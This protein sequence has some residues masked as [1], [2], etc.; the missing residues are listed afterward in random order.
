MD[1]AI[2]SLDV[3]RD[4][5]RD[6]PSLINSLKEPPSGA[7]MNTYDENCRII[8]FG[9]NICEGERVRFVGKV[10]YGWEPQKPGV[11][12]VAGTMHLRMLAC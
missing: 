8:L 10:R 1:G 5:S 12:V 2:R 9:G 11:R 7:R 6:A 4:C 3:D